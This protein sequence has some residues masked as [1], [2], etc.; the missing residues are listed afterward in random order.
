MN[1]SMNLLC[2]FGD[3]RV[4]RQVGISNRRVKKFFTKLP[5]KCLE[6]A[7]IILEK[8]I[9]WYDFD[10]CESIRKF[11]ER[12]YQSKISSDTGHLIK[13]LP[14]DNI[15]PNYNQIFIIRY[16]Y[17]LYNCKFQLDFRQERFNTYAYH[18]V[19]AQLLQ[20]Q[21]YVEPYF[22]CIY[23]FT[24]HCSPFYKIYSIFSLSLIKEFPLNQ[25][26]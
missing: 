16:L 5:F 21:T 20:I 14:N 24:V 7:M 13:I 18:S 10:A 8:V 4:N 22:Y 11:T 17:N 25:T 12:K 23:H 19:L 15:S 2:K 26:F 6:V 3:G 9:Q 1:Q